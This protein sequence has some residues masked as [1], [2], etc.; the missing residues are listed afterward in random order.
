MQNDEIY[1]ELV[2]V[3]GNVRK[4]LKY[5]ANAIASFEKEAGISFPLFMHRVES[6]GD[7]EEKILSVMAVNILRSAIWAGLLWRTN[8]RPLKVEQVGAQMPMDLA[9][10][11]EN[12]KQTIFAMAKAM[13]AGQSKELEEATSE[14]FTSAEQSAEEEIP[15]SPPTSSNP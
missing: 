9:R 13:G 1:V 8:K 12:A 5:D 4:A 10:Y 6:C 2:T 7:D 11:G 15:Q 3:N 14:N